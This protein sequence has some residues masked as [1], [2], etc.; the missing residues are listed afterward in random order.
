MSPEQARGTSCDKRSDIWAF[1]VVLFEMLS[2]NRPF[3]GET[4]SDALAAVLRA[5][6]DW[7]RLPVDTPS[8]LRWLLRQCLEKDPR[9]RLRDIGDA[10][11]Q[12]EDNT[13]VADSRA[14]MSAVPTTLRRSGLPEEA[15]CWQ[16]APPSRLQGRLRGLETT[17]RVRVLR[18]DGSSSRRRSAWTSTT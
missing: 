15:A 16:P 3:E 6:P 4:V 2:G 7:T 8:R 5:E 14:P 1:G 18:S 9:R 17:L 11:L 13:T 10:R 12:L